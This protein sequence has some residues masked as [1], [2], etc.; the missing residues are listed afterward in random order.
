MGS[1]IIYFGASHVDYLRS[2]TQLPLTFAQMT[3]RIL[4]GTARST[5]PACKSI[6]PIQYT[7][8]SEAG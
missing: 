1:P 2:L 3:M 4:N 8:E 7:H 6:M 5:A